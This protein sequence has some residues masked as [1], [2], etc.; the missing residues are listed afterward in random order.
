M[1]I[2]KIAFSNFG[3]IDKEFMNFHFYLSFT[4][5]ALYFIIYDLRHRLY[6]YGDA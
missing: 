2:F 6:A 1:I 4:G 3:K 5:N